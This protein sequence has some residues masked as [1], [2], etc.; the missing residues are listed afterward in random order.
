MLANTTKDD[1][2]ASC[3]LPAGYHVFLAVHLSPPKR[4]NLIMNELKKLS[5]VFLPFIPRPSN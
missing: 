4:S 1:R 3:R 2:A 5:L